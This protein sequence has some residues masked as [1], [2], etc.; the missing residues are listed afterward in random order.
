MYRLVIVF[1]DHSMKKEATMAQCEYMSYA[2]YTDRET[3]LEYNS[4]QNVGCVHN[5]ACPTDHY[6]KMNVCSRPDTRP[7]VADMCTHP[8]KD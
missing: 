6:G 8:D 7:H 3:R 1:R 5:R 4:C 2:R